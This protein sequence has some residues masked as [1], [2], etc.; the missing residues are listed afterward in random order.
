[1]KHIIPFRNCPVTWDNALPMG[2]SN[3]GAMLY[4]EDQKL[5]M[6]MNHYEV[7][8]TSNDRPFPEDWL[9]PLSD[10][11]GARGRSFAERAVRNEP[12]GDEPYI[13]YRVDRATY[14]KNPPYGRAK[15]MGVHPATGD[16]AFIPNECLNEGDS[17]L[18][19]YVEDA[20]IRF[21]RKT[22]DASL[23]VDT[24]T[25]RGDC[26]VNKVTQSKEGLLSAFE[27]SLEPYRDLKAPSV[28][29]SQIDD[30]TFGYTVTRVFENPEKPFVF[31]G[32]IRLLGAK[33]KLTA[34]EFTAR[35]E[36]TESE[37]EFS[38]CTGIYTQ[39]RYADTLKEGVAK[40]AEDTADLD[41]LYREHQAYWAD[42]FRASS[43]SLPDKFLETVYYV[44][45]Y[46]LDCCS[47]ENGY[48]THQACGLNGL[49]DIRHPNIWGSRWYWDVNIQAAFAGVFSSNRLNLG[50]VFSDGLLTYVDLAERFARNVHNMPGVAMDFPPQNYYS[51]WPW[52]AQYLW[53]QY[54]Y[55]GDVEY[56][57]KD[58]YPLF[59]KL[60]QFALAL[61][62]YDEKTDTYNVYPDISPEQG[63]LTHN[64]TITIASVKYML[65]FTLKSAEILG[66]NDPM[67]GDVRNLLEK[68]PPYALSENGKW[69]VHLKDSYDAPDNMWL[70]H[71][72]LL[73]PLFPTGE[74][75]PLAADKGLLQTLNNT[76]N[77]MID[78]CEIGIFGGSWI[79]AAAAR[80][81]RGQTALRLL[82]ERGI[83]HMLRPNGLT[84]E[85]TD[86]F[87]NHCLVH[88]Q[89]LYYPCMM[90]FTGQMLAAVNEMLLQSYNGVIR[91]F[92][93]L[94]DGDREW[95]RFHRE[96]WEIRDFAYRCRDYEA[97]TDARFDKLLARGA[98]EISA[99]L[100]G[101]KLRFVAVHSKLGGTPRITSPFL[102][103]G[104]S[105]FCNGKEIPATWEQGIVSFPTEAGC[106][107]IIAESADVETACVEEFGY[108]AD[109]FIHTAYTK[110]RVFIG[111][112]PDTKF[113]KALDGVLYDW[114]MSD[115][116]MCNNCHYKFDFGINKEKDY[117]S[118]LPLQTFSASPFMMTATAITYLDPDNCRYQV[119]EGYGLV[120]DGE[121]TAKERNHPDLLRKDFLEGTEPA[122]FVIDTPRG[123]FDFFLVSG[124]A[125]E[126]SVT[127]LE[128]ENGFRVGGDVVKKGTWQ[129][130]VIPVI[131][132]KDDLLRLK[133]STKPGYK[134]KLNLLIMNS[135]KGY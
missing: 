46:A 108:P 14:D 69:G 30:S 3:F 51:T 115:V 39:Y 21:A 94:P 72:S 68:L 23:T 61:F 1:M 75:D 70:R 97:W 45:Q 9:K 133:I 106:T 83:D 55:S 56:L 73:M 91:V 74:F 29:F 36:I 105:V 123:Q 109:G 98:F 67:L 58:A 8:Y 15:W 132:K 54:E 35:V 48:M 103:E 12:V 134:W 47:G 38:V 135:V 26:I 99:E 40:L 2:N 114:F 52:C 65:R 4:F 127:I 20:C 116:R 41:A 76:V 43:L 16:I 125:E 18:T 129:Y 100:R 90:E 77:F 95:D 112:T 104:T 113:Y 44:N 102:K 126:D 53:N 7:Y 17:E 88:H 117:A 87:M 24:I 50:K 49:W 120:S 6:P 85:Q 62:V 130:D 34:G 22:D 66:D 63:P 96:G 64:T 110:R 59:K 33:G 93:A 101:G 78:N 13:S 31:S 124:D 81:G 5:L 82:Y 79:S 84:A 10:D 19:L 42:F 128:T 27:I 57:R 86:R 111:E 131:H 11:P 121:I 89:P 32:V 92:P 28:T 60:C 119:I 122:E 71:P 25:A 37:K 107:Y 80:L 118:Q